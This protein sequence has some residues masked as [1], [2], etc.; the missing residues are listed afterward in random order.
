M[1]LFEFYANPD[2]TPSNPKYRND[3][4]QDLGPLK[5]GQQ[6]TKVKNSSKKFLQVLKQDKILSPATKQALANIQK[7]VEQENNNDTPLWGKVFM[8]ATAV[9]FLTNKLS[10]AAQAFADK[11]G[12]GDIDLDDMN[13]WNPEQIEQGFDQLEQLTTL[14]KSPQWSEMTQEERNAFVKFGAELEG[15]LTNMMQI[16]QSSDDKQVD[17]DDYIGAQDE[18]EYNELVNKL[19]KSEASKPF[20]GNEDKVKAAHDKYGAD[21]DKV[22]LSDDPLAVYKMYDTEGNYRVYLDSEG[23][24]TVGIGHLIDNDSPGSVKNLKVGDTITPAQAHELFKTDVDDA[25]KLTNAAIKAHPNLI[26]VDYNASAEVSYQMGNKVWKGFPNTMKLIDA[27][28]YLGAS[29]EVMKSKW[30]KQTPQRAKAFSDALV[31]AHKMSP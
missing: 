20:K 9:M 19:K 26:N 7:K 25:V 27:G 13:E 5:I 22:K 1:R 2:A 15:K 31:M 12:D 24:P 10:A 28:D 30:A 11:D 16:H 14:M 4:S 17:M 3:I 23:K 18:M 8:L 6:S 21:I 29:E